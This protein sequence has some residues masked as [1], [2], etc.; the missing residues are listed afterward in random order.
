MRNNYERHMGLHVASEALHSLFLTRRDIL[1]Y[2]TLFMILFYYFNSY[3]LCVS[4]FPSNSDPYE[5]DD[6]QHSDRIRIPQ[7]FG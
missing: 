7:P 3:Q 5:A 2:K 1:L 6:T 4:P